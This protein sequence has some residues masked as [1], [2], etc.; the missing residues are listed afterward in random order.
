ML[1]SC[2]KFTGG[3]T[4][5][6]VWKNSFRKLS[7][8]RRNG[9]IDLSCIS[10]WDGTGLYYCQQIV[11]CP[12]SKCLWKQNW[13]QLIYQNLSW[14]QYCVLLPCVWLRNIL[15]KWFVTTVLTQPR[16]VLLQPQNFVRIFCND[17]EAILSRISALFPGGQIFLSE[18][19][20][21]KFANHIHLV[22]MI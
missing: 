19:H 8:R 22:K 3:Q 15:R 13:F 10:V 6:V 21:K 1:A 7:N 14:L 17:S 2:V 9:K 4:A 18:K 12:S 11:A 16:H 5:I 20:L